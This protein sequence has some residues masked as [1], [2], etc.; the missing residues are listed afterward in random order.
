MLRNV[1]LKTL[2][3][4]RR[5]LIGWALG[6]LG[7]VA[8]VLAFY[9]TIRDSADQFS[10][11]LESIPPA[12]R[13][14][15]GRDITDI[16]TPEGYLSGQVFNLT[17]PL[18][19]LIFA[20]SFAGRTLAGEEQ[21]RTLELVLST[22][23][24]RWRLVAEKH[25]A[26]ATAT[27]LLGLVL[28]AGLA[29]GTRLVAMDVDPWRIGQVVLAAVLLAVLFGSVALAIGALT[30]RRSLAGGVAGA[31]AFAAY[32]IDAFA[33]LTETIDAVKGASPFYY[34]G[35]GDPLRSGVDPLHLAFLAFVSF[36]GF[37]VALISFD[38]RDVRT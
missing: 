17:A 20:I 16:G 27:A 2:R 10:R 12:L 31:L 21:E 15:S 19:L 25:A 4:R 7:F 35:A 5:S 30:G 13:A 36:V 8:F 28:W 22:P 37:A 24:P 23:I 34:Y 6:L 33:P 32:L 1:F 26:M 29:V 9:P 3:D 18:L 38:R 14:I 11:L